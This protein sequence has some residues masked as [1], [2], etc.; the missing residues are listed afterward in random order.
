MKWEQPKLK[1]VLAEEIICNFVR[2][3]KREGYGGTE[4]EGMKWAPSWCSVQHLGKRSWPLRYFGAK[5][6]LG[7][8]LLDLI[9]FTAVCKLMGVTAGLQLPSCGPPDGGVMDEHLSF[10]RCFQQGD[11]MGTAGDFL[12]GWWSTAHMVPCC[13]PI[14]WSFP[15]LLLCGVFALGTGKCIEMYLQKV[16]GANKSRNCHWKLWCEW[17]SSHIPQLAAEESISFLIPGEALHFMPR[18]KGLEMQVF[19]SEKSSSIRVTFPGSFYIQFLFLRYLGLFPKTVQSLDS[20]YL[21]L[22]KQ[23]CSNF[24]VLFVCDNYL[25]SH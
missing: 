13:V 17:Q 23:T 11:V 7:Q 10:T 14:P 9:F 3:E 25:Q 4:W 18:Q 24:P 20:K 21:K 2:G 22:W 19:Q 12:A 15:V 8:H 6:L 5:L 1:L 16:R